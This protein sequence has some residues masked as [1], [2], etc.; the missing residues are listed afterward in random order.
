[1]V[2]IVAFK[3]YK[4]STKTP[5]MDVKMLWPEKAL[6]EKYVKPKLAIKA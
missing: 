4:I 1:M 6:I 2:C 3:R 5:C